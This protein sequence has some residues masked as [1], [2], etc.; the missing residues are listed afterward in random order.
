MATRLLEDIQIAVRL[1]MACFQEESP[2]VDP[3]LYILIGQEKYSRGRNT[4][5]TRRDI[6]RQWI[7]F[8]HIV[9]G[10][11]YVGNKEATI[12]LVELALRQTKAG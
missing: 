8:W 5:W 3:T 4:S 10:S 9:T 1:T 12:F 11:N 2:L 7:R 6:Y